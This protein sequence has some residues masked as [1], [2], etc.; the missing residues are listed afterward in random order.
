MKKLTKQ[1]QIVYDACNAVI[2][3]A[4]IGD[5]DKRLIGVCGAL[6]EILITIPRF[7]YDAYD[8]VPFFAQTWQHPDKQ[9]NIIYP[10]P[11]SEIGSGGYAPK[12][13]GHQL[14]MRISLLNHIKSNIHLLSRKTLTEFVEN[15][16]N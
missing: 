7:T 6:D 2:D 11:R 15:H 16:L 10:I 13:T 5:L 1:Q 9:Q 8:I 4:M 12:W 14:Q 3:M